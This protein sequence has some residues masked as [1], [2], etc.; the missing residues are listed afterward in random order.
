MCVCVCIC[1]TDGTNKRRKYR[2][3]KSFRVFGWKF[4]DLFFG[5]PH[6]SSIGDGRGAPGGCLFQM[7]KKKK[8]RKKTLDILLCFLPLVNIVTMRL[9]LQANRRRNIQNKKENNDC[10]V[11]QRSPYFINTINHRRRLH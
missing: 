5:D 10:S 1:E 11:K 2:K 6:L 9:R 7:Q 4:I 3:E 8:R